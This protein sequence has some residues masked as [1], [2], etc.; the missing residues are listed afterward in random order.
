[1]KKNHAD[2]MKEALR[3][4]SFASCSD[5]VPIGAVMTY[6]DKIIARSY[7]QV[8]LLKDPTAHAEMLAI[9]IATSYLKSKW[10]QEC[11]LYVTVEPCLMCAGA[12]V[13]SRVG[14]VIF[15]AEDPKTGAF[16]SKLDIGKLR[17]NHKIK[18]RKGILQ[19]ECSQLMREFFKNKRKI[20]KLA[21]IAPSG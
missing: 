18:V 3:Q 10:L 19:G 2:Y 6:H 7:N 17:L 20:Q 13:L 12:C 8:E 14:R 16:G 1:M 5:E 15:G 21:K 11:T 4:A 9:T